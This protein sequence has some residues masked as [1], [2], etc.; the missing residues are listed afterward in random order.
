[1]QPAGTSKGASTRSADEALIARLLAV[2]SGDAPREEATQLLAPDVISHMDQFTVRGI[3]VWFDWLDFLLS[4]A[5]GSVRVDLNRFEH[6]SDGTITAYGWLRV[7]NSPERTPQQNW[8]RY[9]V[10]EN[11]ISE[12]WTTRGNYERIFGAKVRHP[13]SWFLVLLQMAVWRRLPW[14]RRTRP[15]RLE[16]SVDRDRNEPRRG[17]RSDGHPQRRRPD[18]ERG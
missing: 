5:Q 11:R 1:M 10:D 6:H 14:T 16:E 13:L 4:N 8:A 15:S 18:R 9:R 3:D 7:E 12:V 17:D 2:I